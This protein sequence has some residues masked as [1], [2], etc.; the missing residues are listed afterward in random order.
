MKY[1]EIELDFYPKTI[2]EAINHHFKDSYIN[3]EKIKSTNFILKIKDNRYGFFRWN[4][5]FSIDKTMKNENIF[6]LIIYSIELENNIL[7]STLKDTKNNIL[8]IKE[9]KFSKSKYLYLLNSSYNFN[10]QLLSLK[11][12]TENEYKNFF[13]ENISQLINLE[14]VL[15]YNAKAII[16][17]LSSNIYQLPWQIMNYPISK[18]GTLPLFNVSSKDIISESMICLD[19][20]YIIRPEKLFFLKENNFELNIEFWNNIKVNKAVFTSPNQ[21]LQFF[22]IS[23]ILVLLAH[24][25]R[26]KDFSS[27]KISGKFF[28]PFSICECDKI[29]E[30]IFLLCCM[31]NYSDSDNNLICQLIKKGVKLILSTPYIMP[32][33]YIETICEIISNNLFLNLH[34]LMI[35]ILSKSFEISSLIRVLI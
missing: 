15:S 7:I 32:I 27:I 29:S 30:V 11:T 19:K 18:K 14:K 20:N 31:M 2:I 33:E 25:F 28:N 10:K 9:T 17:S 4:D 26:K 5:D 16:F 8:D 6:E 12:L 34:E 1:T 35:Q 13:L 24:G 21:L 22:K 3:I 23:T